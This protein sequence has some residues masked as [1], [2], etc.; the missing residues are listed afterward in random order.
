MEHYLLTILLNQGIM[1]QILSGL[2]GN[3]DKAKE[4]Y[5]AGTELRKY[6]EERFDEL[7]ENGQ[8]RST[9]AAD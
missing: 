4:I 3:R 6:C 8:I 2:V 1:L 5:K 9:E 7:E